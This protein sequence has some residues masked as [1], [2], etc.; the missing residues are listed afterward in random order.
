MDNP[1]I[2]LHTFGQRVWLDN[3]SRTLLREGGRYVGDWKRSLQDGKGRYD[4]ADGSWYEGEWKDGQP[5]GQGEYRSPDGRLFSGTWKNGV[6][7]GDMEN[8][9]NKT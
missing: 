3:L 1:L 6:F 8:D 9:P 5:H 7:E 2:T 4:A